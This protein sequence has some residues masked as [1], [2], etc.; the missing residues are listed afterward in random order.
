M[1]MSTLVYLQGEVG[2]GMRGVQMSFHANFMGEQTF[3]ANFIGEQMSYT[4][5]M[6][7]DDT[8]TK[9]FLSGGEWAQKSSQSMYQKR[10]FKVYKLRKLEY[11]Y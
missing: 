4:P 7:V 3:H 10:I 9:I 2:G 6:Q 11:T 5:D 1:H 8:M